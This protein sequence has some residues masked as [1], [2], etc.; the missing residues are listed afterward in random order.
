MPGLRARPQWASTF[1]TGGGRRMKRHHTWDD[2]TGVYQRWYE[3]PEEGNFRFVVTT[4]SRDLVWDQ[5]GNSKV[6]MVKNTYALCGQ[7]KLHIVKLD[8]KVGA[9]ILLG[10]HEHMLRKAA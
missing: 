2:E 5:H 10:A 6:V 3:L 1:T 8:R 7:D 4:R 9:I